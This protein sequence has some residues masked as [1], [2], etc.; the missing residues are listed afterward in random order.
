[1]SRKWNPKRR[2]YKSDFDSVHICVRS[3]SRISTTT[4]ECVVIV[5]RVGSRNC[6]CFSCLYTK[7]EKHRVRHRM[8]NISSCL[9]WI[10]S[11]AIMMMHSLGE[12]VAGPGWIASWAVSA[13]TQSRSAH[14]ES[15][16]ELNKLSRARSWY[17]LFIYISV[18]LYVLSNRGVNKLCHCSL[19]VGWSLGT[20]TIQP[21]TR[22]NG[23]MA[24]RASQVVYHSIRYA[25]RECHVSILFQMRFPFSAHRT[26]HRTISSR[27]E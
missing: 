4:F 26:E 11:S 22:D 15:S 2:K 20:V 24:G 17:Y 25:Q 7:R 8:E 3:L 12:C 16:H 10:Y 21:F 6:E 14:H 5:M 1:M 27:N 19:H 13:H 9:R 18:A 23:L